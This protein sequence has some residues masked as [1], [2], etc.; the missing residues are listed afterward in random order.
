M[1]VKAA[2]RKLSDG[3]DVSTFHMNPACLVG[4][5]LRSASPS[6]RILCFKYS[7]EDVTCSS[8]GLPSE[9]PTT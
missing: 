6:T 5:A 2:H 9:C 7:V 8:G 1:H 3:L 4:G